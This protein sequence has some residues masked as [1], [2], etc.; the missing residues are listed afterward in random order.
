MKLLS[1]GRTLL[2]FYG[3]SGNQ[4]HYSQGALGAKFHFKYVSSTPSQFCISNNVPLGRVKPPVD[5]SQGAREC[6]VGV[7]ALPRLRAK[8]P[9]C[10]IGRLNREH[11]S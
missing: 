11:F 6:V 9:W 2:V 4:K 10:S 5:L 1:P 8:S 7:R 3:H